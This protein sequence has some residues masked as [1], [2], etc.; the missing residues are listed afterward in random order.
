MLYKYINIQKKQTKKKTGYHLSYYKHVLQSMLI[1][2]NYYWKRNRY[3]ESS[4]LV[5][6]SR[7]FGEYFK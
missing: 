7:G 4:L 6:V 3:E 5:L 2:F 1:G